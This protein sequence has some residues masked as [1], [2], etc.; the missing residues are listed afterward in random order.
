MNFYHNRVLES[1]YAIRRID[2]YRASLRPSDLVAQIIFPEP[3]GTGYPDPAVELATG[4][5][6]VQFAAPD[7]LVPDDAYYDVWHYIGNDPGT[8]DLDNINLWDSQVGQF[9]LF[10]DTWIADDD[11]LTKRIGFEPLDKKFRRG[12]IRNLEVALH[13][14][15]KYEYDFNKIAPIIPQ[16]MPTITVWTI[17]DELL[18]SNVPC[19]IGIRQGHHRNSPFVVQCPLDT[20]TMIR[21]TYR[22]TIEVNINGNIIISDKFHFA[23]L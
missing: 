6:E 15:P 13:P 10:D 19:K 7:N 3:D 2:I 4:I 17:H 16:L 23:V 20:R 5:F 18:L 8:A 11:L 1:P 22:Y 21:G 12:E 14:L 9:W